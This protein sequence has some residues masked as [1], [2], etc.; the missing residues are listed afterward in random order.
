[1]A[2]LEFTGCELR[3]RG[4][5]QGPYWVS[6]P[7]PCVARRCGCTNAL[8][9]QRGAVPTAIHHSLNSLGACLACL[10]P[11]TATGTASHV[12]VRTPRHRHRAQQ[13]NVIKNL[14]TGE[15]FVLEDFEQQL[16]GGTQRHGAE[17]EQ[18]G[19]GGPPAA[20]AP[21]HVSPGCCVRRDACTV[22]AVMVPLA[23]AIALGAP[24]GSPPAACA[25]VHSATRCTCVCVYVCLR[26]LVHDVR[27]EQHLQCV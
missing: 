15:E 3:D 19:T 26:A 21:S 20:R 13:R 8:T 11:L 10:L 4:C 17:H 16:E 24:A 5:F 1:M 2:G 6:G 12:C 7:K 27:G 9:T 14:D 23:L 22:H 18:V 25:C